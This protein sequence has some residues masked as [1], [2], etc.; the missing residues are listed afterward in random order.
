MI[1]ILMVEVIIPGGG[2]RSRRP[3]GDMRI[4]LDFP[5]PAYLLHG[6]PVGRGLFGY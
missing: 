3:P 5:G 6:G 4:D 2:R 1:T